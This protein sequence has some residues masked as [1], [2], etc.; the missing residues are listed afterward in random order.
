MAY[1]NAAKHIGLDAIGAA[2]TWL[3]VH[4][5]DPG[6]TGANEV[7]GS[8]RGQTTWSPAAGGAKSGTQ[9]SIAVPAGVTVAYWGLWSAASGGTFLTGGALPTPESYSGAGVYLLTPTLT[10]P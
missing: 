8:T 4:T 7:S 5:A 2:G 10:A 3:S 6:V 1:S 9:A